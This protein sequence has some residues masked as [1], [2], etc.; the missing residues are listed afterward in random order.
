MVKGNFSSYFIFQVDLVNILSGFK[1]A[2]MYSVLSYEL[3]YCLTKY[4]R[5]AIIWII[6]SQ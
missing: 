6:S 1:I 2:L 5:N 3:R 4:N